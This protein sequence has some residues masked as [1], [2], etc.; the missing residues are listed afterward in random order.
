MRRLLL[1]GAALVT[2]VGLA[3]ATAAAQAPA[4]ETMPV[5]TVQVFSGADS[6]C[7]FD[8]TFTGTG[9]VKVT[10]F[11]DAAGNPVR[12]TVHGALVHSIFATSGGPALTAD[13]PA[14]VHID[15]VSGQSV[16]TG[17]EV[18]FHVPGAGVVFGQAGRFVTSGDGSPLSFTGMSALD[19]T[20]L[21]AALAP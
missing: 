9:T 2:A 17:D 12:Q 16:V 8:V 15:L 1:L 6:P 4:V 20:A 5:D 13:G 18:I 14:P 19:T 21:C 10:T 3:P 7:P 11:F